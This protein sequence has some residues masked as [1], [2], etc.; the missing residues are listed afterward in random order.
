MMLRTIIGRGRLGVAIVSVTP[1]TSDR[2][3]EERADGKAHSAM[4]RLLDDAD[5]VATAQRGIA[6]DQ[7]RR[8]D[9]PVNRRCKRCGG[10][11][12]RT[13]LTMPW[14]RRVA[15]SGLKPFRAPSGWLRPSNPPAGLVLLARL[16]SDAT[17]AA[18]RDQDR[19]EVWPIAT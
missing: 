9:Y 1:V 16:N 5:P 11:R 7:S 8:W 17:E 6:W 12:G 14:S 3:Q 18:P 19:V 4:H 10:L 2:H 13:A 15:S